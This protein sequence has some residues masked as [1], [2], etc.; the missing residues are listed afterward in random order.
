MVKQARIAELAEGCEEL[1][2]PVIEKVWDAIRR[3]CE[4]TG[5]QSGVMFCAEKYEQFADNFERYYN[6]F[7][8]DFM[9]EKTTELDEHKQAAVIIVSAIE[10]NAIHQEVREGMVALAPYAI[11][12]NVSLN[13]L[14]DRINEKLKKVGEKEITELFLPFPLACDT[15][16]FE[17]LCRILYL[18]NGGAKEAGISYPMSFSLVEWADRFFLLE[19]ILLQQ[20]S[21][22]PSQLREDVPKE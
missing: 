10:A 3:T 8:N 19:Y 7:R 11:P 13:F 14:L 4:Q 15:P 21:I 12:L 20:N 2:Q 5:E 6:L 22:N 16:Y 18:E 17:S 1:L 9:T